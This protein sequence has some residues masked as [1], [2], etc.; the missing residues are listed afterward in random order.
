[1][2]WVEFGNNCF[3]RLI[4]GCVPGFSIQTG[5]QE[6][7]YFLKLKRLSGNSRVRKCDK[8]RKD[9]LKLKDIYGIQ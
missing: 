1:M 5:I 7:E 8:G 3:F 9:C 2:D 6:G 4:N